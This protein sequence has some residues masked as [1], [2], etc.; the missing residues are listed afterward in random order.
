MTISIRCHFM[1]A[2]ICSKTT[3]WTVS[4]LLQIRKKN[5]PNLSIYSR[6]GKL[7]YT[8]PVKVTYGRHNGQVQISYLNNLWSVNNFNFM[9]ISK[10]DAL[11]MSIHLTEAK[12]EKEKK[13]MLNTKMFRQNV[14]IFVIFPVGKI[15]SLYIHNAYIMGLKKSQ[16]F[17]SIL[18]WHW[19]WSESCFFFS[20]NHLAV[21]FLFYFCSFVQKIYHLE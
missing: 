3:I 11:F 16:K 6:P 8:V 1:V 2:L 4:F 19:F 9:Q 14:I 7:S 20:R 15:S 17:H 10:V 21:F 5:T 18:K 12:C 13:T